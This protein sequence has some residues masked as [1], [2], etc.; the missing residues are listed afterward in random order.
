[1]YVCMYVCSPSPPVMRLTC[2][3]APV[4]P[5]VPKEKVWSR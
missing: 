2:Y 3:F 5:K 1:M 4:A